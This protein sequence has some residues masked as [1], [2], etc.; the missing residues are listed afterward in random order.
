MFFFSSHALLQT[1]YVS[2][3]LKHIYRQSDEK[4]IAILNKVRE[5]RI[6][7][8]TLLELNKRYIP[9][10]AKQNNEG[11]IT[12]TTHNYQS[13]EL[14]DFKLKKLETE[15]KNFSATVE[16]DF[17]EYSYPTDFELIVKKNAQVM[18]VKND[19]SR[20]KLFYNGKIGKVMNIEE[21][22]IYVKCPGD[23][24]E[25]PVEIAKWE[26]Y[27]YSINEQTKEIEETVI[28]SFSQ[29]PLKLAWAI[30]IHKSQGLTFE[31]AIIDA[32]ASFAHG[33]VYVALS[34]CKTLEGM[35]LSTPIA[36]QSIK[37]DTTVTAF[38]SDIERNQPDE[39]VLAQSKNA[40]QQT[41]LFELFDYQL[42]QKRISY[43]IKLLKDHASSIVGSPIN[44]LENIQNNT[45]NELLLVG[46]KFKAQL[47]QLFI[48]NSDIENNIDIQERIKKGS[49]WF[50][51]KIDKILYT[52]LK[53]ISIETDN[54]VVRKQIVE[55]LERITE[56][57]RIRIVCLRACKDG[58]IVKSYIKARAVAT[59]EKPVSPFVTKTTSEAKPGKGAHSK[60][61]S[62]LR[63]WRDDK[64]IELET[65][66]YMI[67][68]Q[69]T[70]LELVKELPASVSELK[71]VKG[72]GLKKIKAFG[73]EIL[74]I[75]R[76]YRSGNGMENPKDLLDESIDE[77]EKNVPPKKEKTE[78]EKTQKQEKVSTKQ[79]SY[80]MFLAGKTIKEISE[81]RQLAATTI[82]GHLTYFIE[83]GEIKAEKLIDSVKL[84]SI[85]NYLKN[86]TVETLTEAKNDLGDEFTFGEIRIAIAVKKAL[87]NGILKD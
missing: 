7:S 76:A 29:Y 13:K 28:G 43:L 35:V 14:N 18:F 39:N 71:A 81:E 56:E 74:T 60:L 77:V 86:K 45:Y 12:L 20:D 84:T 50:E 9:D 69:K 32:Q 68:P 61:Y 36:N 70:I 31:R 75:I 78:E 62:I 23:Y 44:E 82:E 26:N 37:N 57:I 15:A 63:D 27:R 46:N 66:N 80:E 83:T 19:S 10:F 47:H 42:Y 87:E 48:Q 8:E 79:I 85:L 24:A 67:L 25:I 55:N 5:N 41:L 64:A 17:P 40:Y 65:D 38:N 4:F 22:I 72:F 11:Y 6:D 73:E 1:N 33:Q 16:G 53:N 21:G 51:E 34:R 54:K 52:P 59:I 2:I 3:E 30:T 58:F 49:A